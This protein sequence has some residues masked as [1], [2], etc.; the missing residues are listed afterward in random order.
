MNRY[1]CRHDK[2]SLRRKTEMFTFLS[3]LQ[4]AFS[5]DLPGVLSEPWS[6]QKHNIITKTSFFCIRQQ[7]ER[8]PVHF[9]CCCFKLLIHPWNYSHVHSS[10][11]RGPRETGP[12]NENQLMDRTYLRAN[13]TSVHTGSKQIYYLLNQSV[14]RDEKTQMGEQEIIV[15]I[16]KE[17][18]KSMNP[19]TCVCS[20][21]PSL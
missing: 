4:K 11:E 16:Q 13:I 18:L 8:V 7:V 19:W 1:Y 14:W 9:S 6:A 12:R 21:D 10:S 5:A 15:C 2:N 17:G 20:A 3:L